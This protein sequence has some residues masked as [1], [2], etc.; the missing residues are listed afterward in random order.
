MNLDKKISIIIPSYNSQKTITY[1]LN[2]LLKQKGDYIKEIIVV[3]SSDS[4]EMQ[5]I[6]KKYRPKVKFINAGTKVMPA[7]G[8]NLGAI[9]S[10]GEILA[11]LD[12]DAIAVEDWAE[13]IALSY[14]KGYR[15][16]GGGVELPDFQRDIP[17][18]AAQYY[19]QLNEFIP[20]GVERIKP[21]LPGVNVF[22]ERTVFEQVGGFP[23]VRAGEDTIFGLAVSKITQYWFIP[24]ITVAHIFREDLI[25]FLNNQ[26]LLGK[27]NILYRKRY[28]YS[29][30]YRGMIPVLLFPGIIILKLGLMVWRITVSR[31]GELKRFLKVLPL[32]MKGIYYWSR[33]FIR[34][35]FE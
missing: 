33:G 26:E 19:L 3:D 24:D 7:M 16:G 31:R 17:I 28:H 6:I 8:R 9:R 11:F 10:T 1:T 2:S 25:G 27:Y 12:S 29:I 15:A 30:I 35:C 34:G 13:K 23:E 4:P 18:A 21:V 5:D 32:F 14:L 20:A 22:C